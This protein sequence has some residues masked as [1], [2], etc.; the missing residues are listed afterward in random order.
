MDSPVTDP[1]EVSKA[2]NTPPKMMG[3]DVFYLLGGFMFVAL[4]GRFVAAHSVWRTAIL[5]AV[6]FEVSRRLAAKHPWFPVYVLSLRHRAQ[7]LCPIRR[8]Y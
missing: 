5:V 2:M 6:A 7:R 1:H 3:V 8:Q 4:A